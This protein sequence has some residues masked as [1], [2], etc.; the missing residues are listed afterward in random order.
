MLT[1]GLIHAMVC[2]VDPFKVVKAFEVELMLEAIGVPPETRGLIRAA[3]NNLTCCCPACTL[4][5]AEE[6][7]DDDLP[8]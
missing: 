4:P 5:V 7:G 3:L 1:G 2:C 8:F 6:I